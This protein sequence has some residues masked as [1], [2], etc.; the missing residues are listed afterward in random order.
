MGT[1]GTEPAR[2]W[3]VDAANVIGARP[4]G[5]W[6]DR[7]GAARR[8]YRRLAEFRPSD[9]SDSSDSSSRAP[10]SEEVPDSRTGES[11]PVPAKTP[12]HAAASSFPVAAERR[13]GNEAEAG[14]ARSAPATIVLVVE[15]AARAGFAPAGTLAASEPP[16]RHDSREAREAPEAREGHAGGVGRPRLLVRLAPGHGDDTIVE[17]AATQPGPVLVVTADRELRAR[18]AALGARTEG[19]GWLWSLLDAAGPAEP[20]D[21]PAAGHQPRR[22]ASGR[23]RRPR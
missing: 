11:R 9:P 20:P 19:P 4:D 13:D 16:D 22:T 6:R 15:G 21:R 1:S 7:A 2:T 12:G 3:V 5:W 10:S 14:L 23:P 8:L 18:V 17:E